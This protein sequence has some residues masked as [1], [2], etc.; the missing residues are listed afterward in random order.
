MKRRALILLF[1]PV[2]LLSVFSSIFASGKASALPTASDLK[3]ITFTWDGANIDADS[4]STS[5][6]TYTLD[7][8]SSNQY[9]GDSS[10]ESDYC[11]TGASAIYL[12]SGSTTSGTFYCFVTPSRADAG[13]AMPSSISSYA[14]SGDRVE[15]SKSGVG[16]SGTKGTSTGGNGAAS[17]NSSSP[18]LTCSAGFNPLNWLL[19]G[20]VNGLVGI[21]G[22]IDNLINGLLVA[23]GN[24]SSAAPSSIFCSSGTCTDY[25][26]AW[27]SFR[28]IA[29][30][31]LVV[32][33]LI[34]VICE[35][36]GIEVLDAYTIR[37]L[38]PRLVA[39]VIIITLSWQLMRFFVEL[40][41]A[42]GFAIRYL[43]YKPF[44]NLGPANINLSGGGG[45]AVDLATGA[46]ITA[47]G[48]FGL[49]SF[50]AT[51]AIA[52]FVAFLV[53]IIRQLVIIVLIIM[54]PIAILAYILPNTQNIYR[55]WWDS[56]SKALMMFPL[57]AGLIAAGRV[58][59]VVASKNGGAVNSLIA[60]AS[61][62]APYFLIPLTFRFAGGAL[63][64]IGGFVNDRHRGAFDRVGQFRSG[65]V[66]QN[67]TKMASGDRWQ[68]N[69]AAARS[70][71]RATGGLGVG[72]KGRFGVGS[73]GKGAVDLQRRVAARANAKSNPKLQE[74]SFDDNAIAVMALSGGTAAGAKIAAAK[75]GLD[76]DETG[77]AVGTAQSV[78]FNDSNAA[79]ALTLMAQNKSRK[80][81]GKLAGQ[82]G[83][84]LVRE[85]AAG[86]A[87][88]N[89]QLVE[90][91]MGDFAFNSRG[92]GRIDLGGE[93]MPTKDPKKF[94]PAPLDG[95]QRTTVSQHA[96][97]FG[98]STEYF[99]Q[100]T[101]NILKDTTG[102]YKPEDR[103]AAAIALSEMH[104]SLPYFSGEN[105]KH[106]NSVMDSVG[107]DHNAKVSV[108]RQIANVA[109]GRAA[110]DQSVSARGTQ[111]TVTGV[112]PIT[113]ENIYEATAAPAPNVL[114]TA[115]EING[116]ARKYGQNLEQDR[117]QNTGPTPTP[118]GPGGTT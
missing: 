45:V 81:T 113:K 36:L 20:V 93:G 56:F 97:A 22:D 99:A 12:D 54:A 33:G 86:I 74:L 61:Y 98:A 32:I 49:L 42:L 87:H 79:A 63:R 55:I 66:Q 40:S 19:C 80:L 43:I 109:N 51:A 44:N 106:I 46:A 91:M 29:L 104:S 34:I 67:V 14:P 23:G 48:I 84:D 25:Y 88:G 95:W 58:F 15:F 116:K 70:F 105:Q 21:I 117:I 6:A 5:K 8:S 92:A 103:K 37:K 13:I 101:G 96:Q 64:Q 60:F 3:G 52:V 39:A 38:L 11:P 68:G 71:N 89:Q 115:N 2:L 41:N 78:G 57:I 30:G 85:S 9:Y 102:K 114:I 35:A 4:G 16:V 75:L 47:M 76:A 118:T 17:S 31:L 1:I 62:F 7:G 108:E 53:L 28:D 10:D 73:R 90:N 82:D 50:A 59:S 18:S 65:Q 107:I 111:T 94:K 112:D 110:T 77:R 27:S 72:Y 100:E 26:N 83:I 69:N 24:N